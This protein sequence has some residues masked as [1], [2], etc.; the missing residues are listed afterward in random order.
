MLLSSPSFSSFLDHLSANPAALP[1][2]SQS[3]MKTE[4]QQ[5]QRQPPKD[6]NP[7][8]S[9]QQIDQQQIGMAMIPEQT[10]DFSMLTLD[11][12]AFTFQPQVFAVLETPEVPTTLD[13]GVLSGK[14]SNFV[15]EQFDSED[16]KV[17]LPSISHP[18]KT[19]APEAPVAAPADEAFEADPEFALYHSAPSVSAANATEL[20]NEGLPSVDIFGGVESEKVLARY[21]LVDASE[22]EQSAVVAL[23][24]V[25]RISSGLE[26]VMMRL[27]QMS[28]EL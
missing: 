2:T 6:V 22:E 23:A 13:V 20:N 10:M 24:R 14:T 26:S 21:E 12:D 15:G 1:Q 19:L 17:E 5:Q 25:Q 16:E 7:Y 27:E 11:N 28:L 9:G 3:Q 8:T 4:P 18:V